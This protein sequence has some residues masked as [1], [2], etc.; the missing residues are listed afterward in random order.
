MAG[1]IHSIFDNIFT[2]TKEQR[3]KRHCFAAFLTVSNFK[4][5]VFYNSNFDTIPR[6]T[7]KLEYFLANPSSSSA[8]LRQISTQFVVGRIKS[9]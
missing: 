8:N 2:S 7:V 3:P 1:F 6:K 9:S 5:N 4:K